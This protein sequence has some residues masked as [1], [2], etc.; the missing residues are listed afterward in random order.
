MGVLPWF[1]RARSATTLT[2]LSWSVAFL[3][4]GI[5]GC[6]DS[7]RLSRARTTELVEQYSKDR[8][9]VIIRGAR[10]HR[11][12]SENRAELELGDE[13]A[14]SAAPLDQ[15]KTK[16]KNVVFPGGAEVDPESL[17]SAHLVIHGDPLMRLEPEGPYR[18][19]ERFLAG[20]SLGGT[21]FFQGIFRARTLGPLFVEG[22]GMAL[23]GMANGSVGLLVD[24]PLAA[25]LNVHVGGG[26]GAALLV[27]A[28]SE[29]CERQNDPS[30]DGVV[31]VVDTLTLVSARVGIG[32]RLLQSHFRL[33]LDGGVW[34]GWHAEDRQEGEDYEDTILWPMAGFSVLYEL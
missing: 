12:A 21:A 9:T 5:T 10:R 17:E 2:F 16:G 33:E 28:Q 15:L 20:V 34:Y 29:P 14:F 30:C 25:R 19:P 31:E 1:C 27:S 24:V 7:I 22:G 11:L 3:V 18:H 23:P 32:Y 4:V 26:G 6:A 8:N 13:P